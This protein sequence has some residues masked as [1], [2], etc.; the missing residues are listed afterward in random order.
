V[1][2]YQ[3]VVPTVTIVN[4]AECRP[5]PTPNYRLGGWRGKP[6][7]DAGAVPRRGFN[8]LPIDHVRPP[9]YRPSGRL[10]IYG[11]LKSG[12]TSLQAI[13]DALNARSIRTARGGHW[14]PMTVKRILDRVA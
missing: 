8:R 11:E 3:F 9:S 2:R 5:L 13:A 12:A 14:V 10:T 6:E 1:R 4:P 7:Q